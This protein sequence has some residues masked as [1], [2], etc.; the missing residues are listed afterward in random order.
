MAILIFIFIFL[1]GT[2]IGS[3]LNVVIYR[4]NTGKTI[5][6]GRSICMT[7]NRYLRWYELVP[8][9]SF[10]IQKG[11]CRRCSSKISIQYPL[12]EIIT[13]LIFVLVF[14]KFLPILFFS[15]ASYFLLVLFFVII[16]SLLIV[17]AAYDLKHKIIPDKLVYSFIII[18]FLSIFINPSI[19]GPV[20]AWPSIGS[21]ISGPLI[22]L[23]FALLFYFSKGKLMG[24]G[25]VKLILGMGWMLGLSSALFSVVI[26]FW[27]GA[28]VGIFLMIFSN[29]KIGMKTEL[30]FAP[31]LIIST[32]VTFLFSFNIFSLI[33][34]F[35]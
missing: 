6:R 4:L 2:I 19:F 21:L 10:L 31:F 15:P 28:I 30:P 17:V 34:L 29:K 11:R 3:F 1:L 32:L 26:S 23:P 22:A 16:F 8:V 12:V 35:S 20:L 27:I 13:G 14:S 24:F 9:F 7:C 18:S 5:V 33:S 25:D